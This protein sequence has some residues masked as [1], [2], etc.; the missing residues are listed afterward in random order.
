MII[1]WN[2][3][4]KEQR[5]LTV[6]TVL[7]IIVYALVTYFYWGNKKPIQGHGNW[8]DVDVYHIFLCDQLKMF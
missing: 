8:Q 3:D 5:D 7:C 2:E 1:V 4:L 6:R